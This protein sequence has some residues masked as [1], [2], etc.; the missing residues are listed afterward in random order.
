MTSKQ[1]ARARKYNAAL[2]KA[3]QVDRARKYNRGLKKAMRRRMP[4]HIVLPNGMWR[5][6]K[7]GSR[8]LKKSRGVSMVRRRSRR[9]YARPRARS[10]GITSNKLMKGIFPV[11]GIIASALVGAGI[12]T[13]QEKFLPQMIPYQSAL[14]GF[15][16][17][18]VGGAAGALARDMVK[19]GTSAVGN[20]GVT[21]YS[22]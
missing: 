22:Y 20:G 17:G 21:G 18:G 2:D 16:V 9:A 3:M 10:R 11:G 8:K 15:A 12:A 13:L 19:G 14:A 5:F 7:S 6:V 1:R 4:A